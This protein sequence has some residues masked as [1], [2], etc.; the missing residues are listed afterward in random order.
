MA[1]WVHWF[2]PSSVLPGEGNRRDLEALSLP[3]QAE[4]ER[5]GKQGHGPCGVIILTVSGGYQSQK[6]WLFPLNPPLTVGG[7][8]DHGQKMRP[9]L[10]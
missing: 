5:L 1:L 4:D 6:M 9:A 3:R 8:F 10:V 7:D 2:A